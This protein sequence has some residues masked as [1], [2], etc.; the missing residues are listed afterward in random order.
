MQKLILIIII[1]TGFYS[2]NILAEEIDLGINVTMY[3]V[4][5]PYK[6]IEP[7]HIELPDIFLDEKNK[8]AFFY[9]A[10]K[11]MEDVTESTALYKEVFPAIKLD[12]FYIFNK[13]FYENKKF[14]TMIKYKNPIYNSTKFLG[15]RARAV[16]GM[17]KNY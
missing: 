9:M 3:D 8:N 4:I 13:E 7:D 11:E 1:L 12:V 15:I 2:N 17:T 5:K 16:I 10:A 6:E 14:T